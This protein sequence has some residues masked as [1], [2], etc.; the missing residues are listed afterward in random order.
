M[1]EAHPRYDCDEPPRSC[2]KQLNDM[3]QSNPASDSISVPEHILCWLLPSRAA[4]AL[5]ELD[6]EQADRFIHPA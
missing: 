1:L 2:S 5:F 6:R 4:A 3:V